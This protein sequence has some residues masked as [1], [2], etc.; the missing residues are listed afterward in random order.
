MGQRFR[1]GVDVSVITRLAMACVVG[2]VAITAVWASEAAP[3]P[4]ALLKARV[5]QLEAQLTQ[6]ATEQMVSVY[7]AVDRS[8]CFEFRK[9]ALF[10]RMADAFHGGRRQL[11]AGRVFQNQWDQ[12]SKAYRLV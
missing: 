9:F 3:T 1:L 4:A 11:D 2:G 6:A 8:C 12:Y 5:A 7:S 10:Q